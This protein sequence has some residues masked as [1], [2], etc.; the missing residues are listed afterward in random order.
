MKKC[1]LAAAAV[2]ATALPASL[3]ASDHLDT[4]TV[5]EDPSLDIGDL[6]AWTSGDRV[7]LVMTIVGHS[8][9]P[10]AEYVFHVANGPRFGAVTDVATI[11]CRFPSQASIICD[12]P[13]IDRVQGDPRS[14]NGL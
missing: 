7:N 9:S 12:A 2:I 5:I 6:Y 11:R 13:G 14:T 10:D 4:R 3:Q 1:V 8:F